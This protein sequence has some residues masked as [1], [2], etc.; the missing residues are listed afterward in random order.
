MSN[1]KHFVRPGMSAACL[2]II[3]LS[4]CGGPGD[5]VGTWRRIPGGVCGEIYPDKVTFLADNSYVGGLVNWNGGK[6][7]L[8]DRE[9]IKMDTRTGPAL[10]QCVLTGDEL[11]FK[12][13]WGCEVKYRRRR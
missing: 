6:Y 1:I 13:D 10:Y 5:I 9:T 8:L 11:T 3:L 2:L 12:T 7:Q 4:S